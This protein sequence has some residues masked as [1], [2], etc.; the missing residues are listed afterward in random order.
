M[1][2][3][4]LTIFSR[5]IPAQETDVR[6]LCMVWYNTENL[7]YPGDDTLSPDHE[8]TPE[9]TYH[10]TWSRY[11]D[12]LT[13]IAKVIVASGGWDPPA[14]VVLC[15]VE[16]ANVLEELTE[17]PILAPYHYLYI[18]REGPDHRGLEVA[19]LIRKEKFTGMDWEYIPWLPPV[20]ATREMMHL[21]LCYGADT[22][23]LFLVHLISKYGGSGATAQL[24]RTQAGQ[25][26]NCMDSVNAVRVNGMIM[27]MGDFND[28][29]S[30]FS[31]EPLRITRV[32]G[33]TLIPVDPDG[34]EGSYKY[35]GRW[36]N[37]DHV[38]VSRSLHHYLA[39]VSVLRLPQLVTEDQAYGGIKPNRT[40]EGFLYRGGIS[41]HLP[42]VV[43][44]TLSPH[45][46]SDLHER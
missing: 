8:F 12:K 31:L 36:S 41:D 23:D 26:V 18:H 34:G 22:L 45:S 37:I 7:F 9:G 20:T 35:R 40:Y 5:D 24:R 44:L 1:T 46:P 38:L 10:W 28:Q 27:A 21:V 25:L 3:W 30:G 17:H 39:G 11:R 14:L 33:D 16:N 43:R 42:L 29:L 2:A 15:E 6:D 32:G 4:F 13:A 19:C